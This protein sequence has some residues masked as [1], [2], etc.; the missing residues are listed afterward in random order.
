[1]FNYLSQIMTMNMQT[2]NL[3]FQWNDKIRIHNF[4]TSKLIKKG[5]N[6]SRKGA[7]IGEAIFQ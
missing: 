4:T 7:Y 2:F 5:Y 3:Y 1:M 6:Y